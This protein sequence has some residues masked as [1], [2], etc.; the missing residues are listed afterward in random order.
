MSEQAKE[1]TISNPVEAVVRY[2]CDGNR[3]GG[4]YAIY[5]NKSEDD[6]IWI[7]CKKETLPR[8]VK[9]LNNET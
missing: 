5:D 8:I 6:T 7:D 4:Y 2:H 3:I 9:A 1:P